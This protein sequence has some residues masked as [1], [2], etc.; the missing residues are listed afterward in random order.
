[1]VSNL[2]EYDLSATLSVTK[3][4]N[5]S[6]IAIQENTAP[7][8]ENET[9]YFQSVRQTLISQGVSR[10]ATDIILSSLRDSTKK[11]YWTYVR[12]W[13]L[14]CE[15]REVDKFN[16]NINDV[17]MFLSDLFSSG[18]GYSAINTAKSALSS[19]KGIVSNLDI[20]SH[21]LI[22]RF[23]KGIF[24]KKPSLPRYNV[25]WPVS[26][27][28]AFLESVDNNL[29][30]LRDLSKKL[31]TLLAL[32]TG[33]R[34][35]TLCAIDIRNLELSSEYI[36]IR[37]GDLL[38][39]SKPGNH[40]QELYIENFPQNTSLCV[41]KCIRKYLDTTKLLRSSDKLWI[42]TIKPFNE[43][44]KNTVSNWLRQTLCDSGINLDIFKPHS[45][46]AASTSAVVGKVP[47][48]TILRTAGWTSDCVF[49]KHYKRP[50]TNDSSFSNTLLKSA[51]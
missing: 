43:S 28:L 26:S 37:I 30:S 34:V 12:K 19:V 22:K 4:G 49:R 27:V 38:K 17:L 32:T 15:R 18:I 5:L 24:N 2:V 36:K 50:V 20:G 1:M 41:V 21:I 8:E 6:D 48:D 42:S 47:V 10:E 14:F 13:L 11:Q 7:P 51:T 23:M 46:R 44:S 25:T 35:Q 45:T 40:L 31:V 3:T 29:C 9:G 39:Q 16:P 33:Q